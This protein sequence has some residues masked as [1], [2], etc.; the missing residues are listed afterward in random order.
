MAVKTSVEIRQ[1]VK[2]KALWKWNVGIFFEEECQRNRRW[3]KKKWEGAK[4]AYYHVTALVGSSRFRGP[5][6][7]LPGQHTP[8]SLVARVGG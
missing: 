3:G 6:A 4:V 5:L 7:H 1:T 2:N 8:H